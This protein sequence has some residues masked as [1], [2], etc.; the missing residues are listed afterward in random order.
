[1][2]PISIF[3]IAKN[4]ADRIGNTLRAIQELSDDIVV[5]DSG[6]TDGTQALAESLGARV[7]DHPWS[8]YGMQKRFGEDQCRHPWL[9]NLDADEVVTPELARE[10]TA[11]FAKGEPDT[12]A[13]AMNI[14]E[15]FPGEEKPRPMAYSHVYVRLYRK[16]VGRFSGSSVHDLVDLQ[17]GTNIVYLKEI[18]HHY[19]VR[20]LG[21]QL[22]K[23]NRYTDQ[24]VDDL[25]SRGVR[26]PTWRV[27]IELPIAFLKAYFGR[28]HC[29]HGVYG[30]LTAMNYAMFRHLRVAKYYERHRTKRRAQQQADR[31]R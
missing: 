29:V 15:V 10:M 22:E 5:V 18:V 27:F 28:R 1:M 23:F 20:S 9:L 26:I 2:L 17:P 3:L 8:G 13:Y 30:F 6:S 24:L 31:K 19:S 7:I 4:E 11:L 14:V 25:D 16:D 12:S 21:D